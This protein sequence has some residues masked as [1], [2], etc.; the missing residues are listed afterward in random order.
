MVLE[1][2]VSAVISGAIGNL[3]AKLF[4]KWLSKEISERTEVLKVKEPDETIL[5]ALRDEVGNL[6]EKDDSKIRKFIDYLSIKLT[7]SFGF[8]EEPAERASAILIILHIGISHQK[9]FDLTQREK[10]ILIEYQDNVVE[11]LSEYM[12]AVGKKFDE[13][14]S[15]LR[16][17]S[18]GIITNDVFKK[19][20]EKLKEEIK[21]PGGGS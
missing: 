9:E 21:L 20:L 17:T 6:L 5:V 3:T 4:D 15:N 8:D 2:L 7:Q 12:N 1:L 19:V 18:L 16:K 14:K 13:A 10:N 11:A